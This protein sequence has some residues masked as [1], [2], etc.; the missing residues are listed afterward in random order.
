MALQTS[1]T[2]SL[3]DVAAEFGGAAPH[4]ISE[5]Y[6]RAPGVPASGTIDL[7]DFYGKSSQVTLRIYPT[8]YGLDNSITNRANSSDGNLNTYASHY[9]AGGGDGYSIKSTVSDAGSLAAYGD[10]YVKSVRIYSKFQ[11]V[12]RWSST[13]NFMVTNRALMRVGTY[14]GTI[15]L[16]NVIADWVPFPY[17]TIQVHDQTTNAL[18]NAQVKTLYG[19]TNNMGFAM[20]VPGTTLQVD[21]GGG[22]EHTTW[23]YEHFYDL[24]L[25]TTPPL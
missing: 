21:H 23:L 2:I 6:G 19:Y 14:N 18:V 25:S 13:L 15:A 12:S 8:G 16:S 5:Y 10:Y 20:I 17:Q 24:T 22:Y 7:S 9:T 3:L 11:A 1:G 4:A